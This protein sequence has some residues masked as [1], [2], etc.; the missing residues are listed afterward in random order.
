MVVSAPVLRDSFCSSSIATQSKF[1]N[2]ND[3]LH[4]VN[5]TLKNLDLKLDRPHTD[6]IAQL[7]DTLTR[8]EVEQ[9]K[10]TAIAIG[11]W[12]FYPT[13]Q[14]VIEQMLIFAELQPHHRVLEPSAGSGDLAIAL[15]NLGINNINCFELNPLL[16]KA[17]RLQGFNVLGDDFLKSQ[18][19]PIYDRV[20]ANPPF[21]NNGVANHTQQ[22]FKFLKP[23]GRLITLAHHYQLKPSY[24][25]R[26]FFAWLK[27]RNARFL[28][29]GRAFADGDRRTN[30]PLQI[31]IIDKL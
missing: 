10:Q 20:L 14:S 22:A 30:V 13:P 21:A 9:I 17:L 4:H 16:Q 3:Y 26:Q 5:D 6:A 15:A 1:A 28:N 2:L 29:C 31:I 27:K 24:S 11:I 19:K 8:L 25:D 18:P 23:G 7:K 12:D